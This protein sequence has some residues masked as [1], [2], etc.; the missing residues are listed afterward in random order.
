MAAVVIQKRS[1]LT[2]VTPMMKQYLEIKA[3][4]EGYILFYR[5]GDFTNA[6]SRML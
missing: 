5:L 2:T 3:E 1:E 4:Y 6:S